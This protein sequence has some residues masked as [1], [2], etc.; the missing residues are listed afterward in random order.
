ACALIPFVLPGI[1]MALSI[2]RF[3]GLRP[4]T[5]R[6]QATP[7]LLLAASIATSF[8]PYLWAVDGALRAARV[9]TLW[10]AAQTLGASAPR[11]LWR[12]VVPSIRHGIAAG[13][14]L[15]MASAAGELAL[16]RIIT[17]SS[18]ETLPLWQLRQLRG[19]D[20]SPNTLAVSSVL[21]L[22][23]LFAF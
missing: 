1:V 4:E 20:A 2:N 16:A 6:F 17:G 15:V 23:L 8:P 9:Q 13:S 22:A 7:Q 21:G 12:V 5:A 14:L 10:E 11:T 3:V 19:T 18:Y